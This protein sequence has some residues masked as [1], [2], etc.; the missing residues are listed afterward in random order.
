MFL[1]GEQWGLWTGDMDGK[2]KRMMD[3]IM[4]STYFD[5]ISCDEAS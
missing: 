1:V 4:G 5:G 2:S 3:R